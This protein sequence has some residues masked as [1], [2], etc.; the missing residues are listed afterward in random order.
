MDTVYYKLKSALSSLFLGDIPGRIYYMFLFFLSNE[1][2]L[3][4]IK[5]EKGK[6][7]E[8]K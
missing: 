6:Q 3:V 8:L 1:L 4:H 7:S 2:I 5:K